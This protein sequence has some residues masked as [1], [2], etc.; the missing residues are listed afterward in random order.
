MIA[1]ALKTSQ[2]SMQNTISTDGLIIWRRSPI[3][4]CK[5][6]AAGHI[7]TALAKVGKI[8]VESVVDL[9]TT[10][11]IVLPQA[12]A[13]SQTTESIWLRTALRQ[14][15]RRYLSKRPCDGSPTR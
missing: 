10:F 4:G 1:F 8:T 11:T 12:A 15:K 13:V 14:S 2:R 9:G 6:L 7:G 3:S 5:A